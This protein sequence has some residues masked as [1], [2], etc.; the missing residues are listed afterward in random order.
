MALVLVFWEVFEGFCQGF[1]L[2]LEILG[3]VLFLNF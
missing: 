1:A 2:D 3:Q